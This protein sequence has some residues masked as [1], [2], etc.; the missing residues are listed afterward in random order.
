MPGMQSCIG[1]SRFVGKWRELREL[2]QGTSFPKSQVAVEDPE[3]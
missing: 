1:V 3:S 2:V